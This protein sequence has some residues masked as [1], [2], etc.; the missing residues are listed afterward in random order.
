MKT[1]LVY[2]LFALLTLTI[3]SCRKKSSIVIQAHNLT[4]PTDG[5]HFAGQ[6]Y[7]VLERGYLISHESNQV[8]AGTFDENGRA[9]FELKMKNNLN[10]VLGIA[11]PNTVCYQ[12]ITLEY[13]IQFNKS[14]TINFDY[15]PCGYFDIRTNNINCESTSDEHR[16]VFY[17]TDNPD[18]YIYIEGLVI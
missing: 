6:N 10:Y 15:A 16:F 5:S 17:Y 4:N 1:K 12:E 7:V 3:S 13:P 14:N 8:A 9:V 18:I 2:I 11:E